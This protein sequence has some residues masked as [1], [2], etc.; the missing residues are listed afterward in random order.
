MSEERARVK[1]W[2]GQ[3]HAIQ[4]RT[5][6]EH[7]V[8]SGV[9]YGK[10]H[11]A[12][13][14]HH[15][16]KVWNKNS[17]LSLFIAPKYDL[18]LENNIP[19]Y[20]SFL[21][22]IG[23][24]EGRD[25]N[26]TKGSRPSLEY[27][28]GHRVLFR[29]ADPQAVA[30]L[31]SYTASHATVDE[32]GQCAETTPIEVS[33]RVRCPLSIVRQ[34]LYT[35]TPEGVGNFF[36]RKFNKTTCEPIEGT[37]FRVGKGALV[38]QGRT[39]DNK[40]LP[41]DYLDNLYREFSWNENLAKAYIEGEFVPIY[42]HRGYDYDADKHRKSDVEIKEDRPLYVCW[43]FNVTQGRAGGVSWITLQEDARDIWAAAENKG[44]SRTT[45]EAVDDFIRQ[46]PKLKW[47][48]KEILVHGDAAGHGRDTRSYGNDYDII[49]QKLRHAGYSYVRTVAPR[50]NPSV[51]LR[52]AATNRLFS[53]SY[54]S[55]L[56]LGPKCNK[57][58]L[59]QTTINEKGQIVKPAAETHTHFADACG[60]GVV[61]LRPIRKPGEK[62]KYDFSWA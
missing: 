54:D 3:V 27:S 36:F 45:F 10:S 50:A 62:G 41:P 4:D 26:I 60:Y 1:L 15:I 59:T 2:P 53:D 14:W 18:L 23:Q 28:D 39:Y 20:A 43:D 13:R 7:C 56:Y 61:A 57:L 40:E 34:V 8:V 38:L 22:S 24:I 30:G 25:Y 35:G 49:T 29:S 12:V 33:K 16:R 5:Y 51:A 37:Q 48:H 6:P 47:Q 42:D 21:E 58:D 11:Y 19:L 44:S 52:I 46:F 55:T 17:K 32:A 9:G 31:V